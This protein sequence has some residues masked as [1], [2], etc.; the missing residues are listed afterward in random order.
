MTLILFCVFQSQPSGAFLSGQANKVRIPH[1]GQKNRKLWR[2]KDEKL[3]EVIIDEMDGIRIGEMVTLVGCFCCQI[4]YF[5]Y[6]LYFSDTKCFL[7]MNRICYLI[8]RH[9]SCSI[10]SLFSSQASKSLREARRQTV[11]SFTKMQL[12]LY[13]Q[14]CLVQGVSRSED[15]HSLFH[16]SQTDKNIPL[17]K[18]CNILY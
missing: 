7:R 1:L 18:S 13:F 16:V 15:Q 5:F 8:E 14:G 2:W 17:T 3:M 11:M 10:L 4:L 6:L 9:M 12:F